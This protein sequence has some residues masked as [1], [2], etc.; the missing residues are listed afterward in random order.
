MM[1]HP[2]CGLQRRRP[3]RRGVVRAATATGAALIGAL[4][5]IPAPAGAGRAVDPASL[6]PPPPPGA[7]C[8]ANGRQVICHTGLVFDPLNEPV[9]ELPCGM[10]Y[11]SGHD[12][13]RGIRWYV[14]GRL[15]TRFVS[16]DFDGTWSLSPTGGGPVVS[17]SSHATWRNVDIDADADE[18]TWPTSFHGNGFRASAPGYGVIIHIA[19][20][21]SP[22]GTHHGVG[23]DALFE[24][25]EVQAELCAAM[26][27]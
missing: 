23:S 17:V 11:E 8:S 24:D 3:H 2:S 27:G 12:V 14:D 15:T 4:L 19:G 21:D 6:Q 26:G 7:D 25:P 13:R 9:F 10:F 18:E 20:L 22:D 16:G 5:L 1:S